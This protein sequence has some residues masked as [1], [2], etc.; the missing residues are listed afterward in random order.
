MPFVPFAMRLYRKNA[1]KTALFSALKNVSVRTYVMDRTL[2]RL[3]QK[4]PAATRA[5]MCDAC[6]TTSPLRH[7]TVRRML[8]PIDRPA[9][10]AAILAGDVPA[11]AAAHDAGLY[12]YLNQGVNGILPFLGTSSKIATG[13]GI[14]VL[15]RVLYMMPAKASGGASA[16]PFASA[17]CEAACLAEGTGRMSMH[18]SQRAR[19]RRHAS[20]IADRSRFMMA[21]AHEVEAHEREA[22]KRGM[23]PAIRLNGTTDLL[24]ERFPVGAHPNIMAAFPGV[25]FYD[26]TK[27]P[28]RARASRLP[29]N[30]HLTYSLSER[31]DAEAHA[32]EYIGAGYSVAVVMRMG[33][34]EAPERWTLDDRAGI[35]MNLPVIDGDKT[36]CR[37]MD[38]PGSIVAL[39]AK[40]RAKTDT[41]GFV[42]EPR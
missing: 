22:M 39:Y 35:N 37:F 13:E 18:A 17:G 16:C 31:A 40:G 20:F 7:A 33:K 24:W 21:L 19:R 34:G 11:A 4:P 26:Y 28:L 29:A 30:Y 25:R 2:K 12:D 10:A 32:A 42:R 5:P 38:A 8:N 27:V 6:H 15:T 3:T 41:S 23:V 9:T 1:W 14:G 36:D